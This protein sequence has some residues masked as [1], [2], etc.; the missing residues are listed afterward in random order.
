[1]RRDGR[2]WMLAFEPIGPQAVFVVHLT[3]L[4]LEQERRPAIPVPK[5][6]RIDPVPARDLARLQ[7]KENGGRMG[8]A[9]VP[10]ASRKVSR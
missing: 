7:Q 4:H 8:P 6:R 10:G 5:L 3:V 2:L 9:L 1:M